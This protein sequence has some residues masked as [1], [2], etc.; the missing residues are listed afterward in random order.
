MALNCVVLTGRMGKDPEVRTT[1][2]DVSVVTFSIAVDRDY[3]GQGEER[4]TD[5]IRCVAWRSTADYMGK[6]VHKGDTVTVQGRLNC[7]EFT[8]RDGRQR[9]ITEVN[10]ENVYLVHSRAQNAQQQVQEDS[11]PVSL[12]P[13]EGDLPF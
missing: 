10:A 7:T 4:K 5:W 1:R 9:E 8:D 6:Y 13:V 12:P 3:K 2:G 11:K